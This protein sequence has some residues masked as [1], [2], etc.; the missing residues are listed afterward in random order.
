MATT[1]ADKHKAPLRIALTERDRRLLSLVARFHLLSRDQLMALTPFGSLTRANTRLKALVHIGLLNRKSLPVYPGHGSAQSLYYLGKKAAGVVQL[2][3][4]S[5]AS[6]RRQISRWELRQVEHVRAANQVL[7]DFMTAL[8]CSGHS[9]L[10]VFRSEP[11]LRQA[12]FDRALVPDGWIAWISGGRRFNCFIEVDLHHEG[13][14]EWRQKVLAYLDYAES[15]LHQERF[16]FA[17]FR[18]LVLAKSAA[19]LS[20]LQQIAIYA[21][22]LFLF[23][24]LH[25]INR[26]NVLSR[27]WL[28]AAG[29]YP[30][31]LAEA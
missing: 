14:T 30:L 28:P 2:N 16:G 23:A 18:T 8:D 31:A 1:R 9:K 29:S 27:V 11:E 25:Q 6:Q 10:E 5:L 22:R 12:F 26:T 17:G 7:A 20:N 24:D 19:R 13:L 15:G 3:D 21:G 4:R